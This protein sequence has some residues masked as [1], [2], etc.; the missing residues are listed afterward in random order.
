MK[1]FC[2]DL[3]LSLSKKISLDVDVS[4]SGRKKHVYIVLK[5]PISENEFFDDPFNFISNESEKRKILFCN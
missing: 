2:F 1:V 4:V 5:T 3:K